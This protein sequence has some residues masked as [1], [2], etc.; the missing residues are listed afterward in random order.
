VEVLSSRVAKLIKKFPAF[1]GSE[2][3]LPC[4]R[5]LAIGPYPDPVEASPTVTTY[6]F[7]IYFSYHPLIYL[8]TEWSSLFR[9]EIFMR[10]YCNLSNSC[11]KSCHSHH[12]WF[13]M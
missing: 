7:R 2:G 3:S 11:Y 6:S 9:S 13:V 5:Q 4:S 10:F 1:Y 12:P 8:R